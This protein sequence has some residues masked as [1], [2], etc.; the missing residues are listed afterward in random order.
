MLFMAENVTERPQMP[1]Y[2]KRDKKKL[3]CQI[4][5]NTAHVNFFDPSFQPEKAFFC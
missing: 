3:K 4:S 2:G 5:I 1:F